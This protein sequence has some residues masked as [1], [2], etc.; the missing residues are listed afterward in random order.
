MYVLYGYIVYIRCMYFYRLER[1]L[2]KST[3]L[4]DELEASQLKLRGYNQLEGEFEDLKKV[5]ML[6]MYVCIHF[7]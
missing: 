7:N 3:T 6:Y 1:N 5:Y 2:Q 4:S